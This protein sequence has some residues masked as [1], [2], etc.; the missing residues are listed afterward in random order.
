MEIKV[1]PRGNVWEAHFKTPAGERK[2][3]ST[4]LST[5]TASKEEALEEGKRL[6]RKELG[7][8]H[9]VVDSRLVPT[10]AAALQRH[11]DT[12]WSKMKSACTLKY[13][14]PALQKE[15][16]AF[17]P[18]T[19]VSTK[20]LREQIRQWSAPKDQGGNELSNATINRKLTAISTVL[21]VHEEDGDIEKCPT[22]PYLKEDNIRE[23]Y[24]SWE[25][26]AEAAKFMR[27]LGVDA[28]AE[29]RPKWML[30]DDSYVVLVDTG[31]RLGEYVGLTEF[32]LR[33][34]QQGAL[35]GVW[36]K[37][38]ST[39][40]G[41]GRTIPLTP[42]A[43][44]ALERAMRLRAELAAA[45]SNLDQNWYIRRWATVRGAVPSL[46]DVNLHILRHTCA[47][48]L[49]QGDGKVGLGI[50]EVMQWLGHTDIKST[51]RYAHL[52]PG[53]LSQGVHVL[54]AGRTSF[55]IVPQLEPTSSHATAPR[56]EGI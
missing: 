32:N 8:A 12:E 6:A 27:K 22:I 15:S 39:K 35:Y 47:S 29:D 11:W 41:K 30:M 46:A 7:G 28:A 36:L 42:R 20:R 55:L 2:R 37:H 53:R 34:D 44:D 33:R 43:I 48:R 14:I 54:E 9:V 50:Y 23:R 31:M 3:L 38:G 26:E 18:I 16:I 10:L 51:L 21:R 5:H 17:L 40:T 1:K 24:V 45:G 52:A 19:E 13:V 56:M 4:G 49:I 25:E